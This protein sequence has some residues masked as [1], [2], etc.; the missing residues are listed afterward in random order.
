M[1]QYVKMGNMGKVEEKMK[2]REM[3]TLLCMIV[4]GLSAATSANAGIAPVTT[5]STFT[6]SPTPS[7]L[8]DLPHAEYFTWGINFNLAPNEKITSAVLTFTNIW[9]WTVESDDNLFIHLLDNPLAGVKTYFD[10]GGE[11]DNFAG[12]G[13]LVTDWSDPAGGK[14]RNFNL[15]LDFG[16]L[17]LLNALNAYAETIPSPGKANFGFGIDPDCHYYNDG[18]TFTITTQTLKGP[19]CPSVPEPATIAILGIGG[20]LLHRKR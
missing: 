9:D 18:I 13:K 16:K 14:P 6:F 11:E 15:V 4:I 12:Q 19:P 3:R 7:D 8:W 17:G 20:L 10:N 2:K 5:S 1:R